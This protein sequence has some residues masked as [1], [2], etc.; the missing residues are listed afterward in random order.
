MASVTRSACA[1]RGPAGQRV[2]P[3]SPEES[4]F[5]GG[6][7]AVH[8][9]LRFTEDGQP[10]TETVDVLAA[11]P[12][13][14]RVRVVGPESVASSRYGMD[15]ASSNSLVVG[16]CRAYPRPGRCAFTRGMTVGPRT[17]RTS[18]SWLS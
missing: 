4:A 6:P 8:F 5:A 17:S 13:K 2:A 7:V 9:A 14:V 11:G 16:W 3:A 12:E 1:A 18:P 15:A 10:L